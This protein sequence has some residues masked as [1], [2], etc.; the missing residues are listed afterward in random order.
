MQHQEIETAING[1]RNRVIAIKAGQSR[2]RH[3]RAIQG[4]NGVRPR[5]AAKQGKYHRVN[6]RADA[7][8][9]GYV[10]AL[11]DARPK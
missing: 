3:D 6:S 4:R 10:T 7:V 5:A 11:P 2:L 1:V 8:R 9:R